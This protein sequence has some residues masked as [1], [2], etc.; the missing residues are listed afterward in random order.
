[1]D[2]ILREVNFISYH[3]KSSYTPGKFKVYE[4]KALQFI[5]NSLDGYSL[6][7]N[8]FLP[9]PLCLIPKSEELHEVNLLWLWR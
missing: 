4:E 8:N 2:Y 5:D 9:F 1:M 3:G 7:P 6:Q